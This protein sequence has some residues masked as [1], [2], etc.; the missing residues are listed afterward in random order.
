MSLRIFDGNRE[1]KIHPGRSKEGVCVAVACGEVCDEVNVS[2]VGR[3]SRNPFY[4]LCRLF[5]A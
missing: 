3:R 5:S 2:S 4:I 1:K